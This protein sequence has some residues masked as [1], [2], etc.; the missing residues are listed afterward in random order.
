MRNGQ[1]FFE[2]TVYR[3][4]FYILTIEVGQ[5]RY[6]KFYLRLRYLYPED[7]FFPYYLGYFRVLRETT[8]TI[9]DSPR[10]PVS[11]ECEIIRAFYLSITEIS[12]ITRLKSRSSG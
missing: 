7:R 1:T 9:S 12:E 2:C 11:M 10:G 3:F 4:Y 8:H 6:I 5:Y